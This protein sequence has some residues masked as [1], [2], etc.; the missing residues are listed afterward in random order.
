MQVSESG[1]GEKVS[2]GKRLACEGHLG[3]SRISQTIQQD[4]Q[5]IANQRV[6]AIMNT[7]LS[8]NFNH[9]NA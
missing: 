4:L 7:F 2:K 3:P 6:Q 8:L 5:F 1:H 9:N